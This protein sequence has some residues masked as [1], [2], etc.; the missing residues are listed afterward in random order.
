MNTTRKEFL[1]TII[2]LLINGII[3]LLV[4][5]FQ[6]LTELFITLNNIYYIIG[7]YIL[8]SIFLYQLN[9]VFKN[10]VINFIVQLIFLPFNL[11]YL[12]TVVAIPVVTTQLYLYF[13]LIVSF[14]IPLLLYSFDKLFGYVNLQPETW[15]YLIITA[16]VI[17]ATLFQRQISYLTFKILPFTA[18]KSEKIDRVKLVELCEYAVSTNNIKFVIYSLFFLFLIIFNIYNLQDASFY[19]NPNIDKAVLQSFVTFIAF[20]RM[21]SNLK[22]NEFKPSNLLNLLRLSIFKE[23]QIITGQEKDNIENKNSDNN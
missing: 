19:G 6:Y 17:T 5:G 21:L 3:I 12:F 11:L 7:G 16:G 18:R 20:E 13:F 4:F 8:F 22:N 14:I 2:I 10:K 15:C 23:T 1:S 9:R